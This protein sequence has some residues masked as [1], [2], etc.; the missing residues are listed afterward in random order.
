MTMTPSVAFVVPR[1]QLDDDSDEDLEDD[2]DID[3]DEEDDDEEDDDEEDVETWQV[4][5][6]RRSR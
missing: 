6:V 5:E 2:D 1:H 4:A 3:E